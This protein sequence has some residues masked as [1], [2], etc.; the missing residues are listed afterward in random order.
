MPG[1]VLGFGALLQEFEVFVQLVLK[2]E[3]EGKATQCSVHSYPVSRQCWMLGVQL[4]A[5][6]FK[7][8]PMTGTLLTSSPAA[9]Q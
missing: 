7:E 5:R 4:S 6:R 2:S 9:V 8:R 3:E 1:F